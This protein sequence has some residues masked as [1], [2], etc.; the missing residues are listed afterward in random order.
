MNIYW[1]ERNHPIPGGLAS[2]SKELEI[3]GFNGTMYPYGISMGDYFTRIARE[4]DPHSEFKYI[5]A[6]RTYS[7]SPQ[8][9]NMLCSSI[10]EI[11]K[12]RI[13]INLLTGWIDK[14]E[15]QFGGI[16]SDVNDSSS[17]IDRSNFMLKYA[18]E[19]NRISQTKF[20]VSTTNDVVFDYCS[21]NDFTMIVPYVAYKNNRFDFTDKRLVVSI[22]PVIRDVVEDLPE[23]IDVEL[24]TK[25]SFFEFLDECKAKSIAGILLQESY[26]GSEYS[27]II[28]CVKEYNKKSF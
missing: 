5:V 8:Y 11:S 2:R 13:S 27:K 9:L 7:L 20:F 23:N 24:F 28:S 26:P 15:M 25:E 22:A 18:E 3:N 19:F 21:E 16:I 14:A 4:M 6:I 12:D 1:F 17:N 10:D